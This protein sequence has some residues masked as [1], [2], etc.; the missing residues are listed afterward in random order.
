MALPVRRDP[1]SQQ[2][3]DMLAEA[4]AALRAEVELLRAQIHRPRG[5]CDDEAD[6]TL[7][8]MLPRITQGK[9]FS[10]AMLW[11]ARGS[12]AVAIAF[13]RVGLE[14]TRDVGA[15]LRRA[16]GDRHGVRVSRR[17]RWWLA[18]H[19]RHIDVLPDRSA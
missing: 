10:A 17:G 9:R 16:R 6:I 15:W 18:L 8:R 4:L 3:F 5:L 1:I 11:D 13:S 14:G 19:M 12:K 2:Q 7:R